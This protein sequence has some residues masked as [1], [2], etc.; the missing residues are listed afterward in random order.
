MGKLFIVRS[1]TV[2]TA[3]NLLSAHPG[4][5][6]M[7]IFPFGRCQDGRRKSEISNLKSGTRKSRR[8]DG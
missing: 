1:L 4:C 3:S 2:Y 6:K 7:G 8:R 5:K